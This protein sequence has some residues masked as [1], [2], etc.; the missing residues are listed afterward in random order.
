MPARAARTP[1][2]A[3]PAARPPWNTSIKIERTRA[4]TQSGAR[5]C[6]S[7][8]I[9]EMNTIQAAPATSIVAASAAIACRKP[10]IA[11]INPRIATPPDA[12]ASSDHRVRAGCIVSAPRTAPAPKQPK[13]MPYPV[14][15]SLM[16]LATDGIN[17]SSALAKN[18]VRPDRKIRTRIDGEKRTYLS[19]ATVAPAR[20]SGGVVRRRTGR[21]HRATSTITP[22]KDTTLRANAAPTPATAMITPAS[23]G[24]TARAKLN[25]M[26]LSADAAARSSFLTISGRT[27]RH[28]G[29]SI[30]SPAERANVR[31]SSSHG[32]TRPMIVA[33]ASTVATPTIQNS[34]YRISRR[35]STMSPMAPAGNAKTKNGRA[36]A[37]CVSATYIGP[38]PSETMSHA[39]P[40]V[41]MN[42]P[43]SDMTSAIS[44]LRKSGVRNGRQRLAG[45]PPGADSGESA[46]EG[47][48]ERMQ[49][50]VPQGWS[51]HVER[52]GYCLCRRTDENRGN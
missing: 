46:L 44:R 48:R 18:I 33:T 14:G 52:A 26:P 40:T 34:V 47:A 11:V 21:F 45:S 9:T 39:A 10:A 4:L 24:P 3:L 6:T 20:V 17:A 43:M 35:R 7:A 42:V 12:T 27:A 1:D 8:L 22:A 37:V 2:S 51:D 31:T 23:A 32:E 28:V 36:D 38:A 50:I 41:C 13:R 30:A 19:A 16:L 5:L 29:V 49:R 25:S 15:L